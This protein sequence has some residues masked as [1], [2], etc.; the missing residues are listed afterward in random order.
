MG[1]WLDDVGCSRS[2]RG[3][4]TFRRWNADFRQHML[5][6]RSGFVEHQINFIRR[7]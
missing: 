4:I 5:A 3:R 1:A 2:R 6:D 7:G